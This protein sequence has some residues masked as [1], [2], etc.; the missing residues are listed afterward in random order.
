MKNIQAIKPQLLKKKSLELN[1][2]Q[3][4]WCWAEGILGAFCFLMFLALGPFAAIPAFFATFSI[5]KWIEEK[6]K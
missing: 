3:E 1:E 4:G 5:P 2:A 6:Q